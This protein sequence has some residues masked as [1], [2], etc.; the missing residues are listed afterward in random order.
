MAELLRDN[1]EAE[2]R[3]SKENGASTSNVQAAQSR[4]EEPDILSWVQ[5]FGMY[6]AIVLQVNP[7]KSQ[8]LLA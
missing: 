6:T 4:R 2:R 3:R 7:E 1:I 5:C 8:Q